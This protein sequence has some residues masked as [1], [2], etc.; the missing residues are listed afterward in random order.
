LAEKS[1]PTLAHID[2]LSGLAAV[3]REALEK[4]CRWRRFAAQEQ[5]IDR[6]DEARDVFFVIEGQVRVVIYSLS[7]REVTLS[8]VGRGGHFGDLAALDGEPRS[9]SVMALTDTL[10]AEMPH[11][12]FLRAMESH[13]S[14]ALKVL[15]SLTRIVRNSTTRIVDL[16]T[17]GANNRVH[18]ELLRQARLTVGGTN[19][20][21]IS[22]IPV[23]SD[24]AS[25]VSTTRET[26]ARVLNDLARQGIVER[27]KDALVIRDIERLARMVEQVRGD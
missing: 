8:D 7:G 18:A 20:A 12:H 5:I 21:S 2:L 9:A 27:R 4:A 22:P 1:T 23:H 14:I 13:W 25:R 24:I 26:V 19:L 11:N 3:E 10:L 16:S 15:L 17:L 6:Q